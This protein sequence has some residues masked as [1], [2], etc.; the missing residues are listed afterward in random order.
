MVNPL[1]LSGNNINKE[2]I[3]V[4]KVLVENGRLVMDVRVG[5]GF[6]VQT[7]PAIAR[8]VL[9]EHPTLVKHTC[10][11]SAGPTFGAVINNTALPHLFEHLVIDEQVKGT[12]EDT[13][14]HFTAPAKNVIFTGSTEWINKEDRTARVQVSFFDDIIALA[15]VTRAQAILKQLF[16]E[17]CDM[18]E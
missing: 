6:P 14:A 11:N 16:T 5:A 3:Q 13:S 8:A 2:V 4:E 15:A 7:T 1:P 18:L 12:G 10:I 17:R 9:Q